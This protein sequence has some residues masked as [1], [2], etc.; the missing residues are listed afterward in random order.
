MKRQIKLTQS[1]LF[2]L[3]FPL[4]IGCQSEIS[5]SST[6]EAAENTPVPDT[7]AIS[8][9]TPGQVRIDDLGLSRYG[10]PQAHF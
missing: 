2:L 7:S 1:L 4:L 6:V 5:A 10:F 8:A 3:I 9:Q